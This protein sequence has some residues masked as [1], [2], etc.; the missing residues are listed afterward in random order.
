M[1]LEGGAGA[2]QDPFAPGGIDIASILASLGGGNPAGGTTQAPLANNAPERP[3]G[4][5]LGGTAARAAHAK[6]Q[7]NTASAP[8]PGAGALTDLGTIGGQQVGQVDVR[9]NIM[10]ALEAGSLPGLLSILGNPFGFSEA[11]TGR[12]GGVP[13]GQTQN[14]AAEMMAAQPGGAGAGLLDQFTQGASQGVNRPPNPIA[15]ALASSGGDPLLSHIFGQQP[16]PM[17][18]PTQ[19]LAAGGILDPNQTSIVGENGPELI[20]PG[21]NQVIPLRGAGQAVAGD[22]SGGGPPGFTSL[23]NMANSGGPQIQPPPTGG[24]TPGQA[25][26]QTLDDPIFNFD[27]DKGVPGDQTSVQPIPQGQPQ[28]VPDQM[29]DGNGVL[30]GQVGAGG[31]KG[32]SPQGGVP[33]SPQGPTVASNPAAQDH[34]VGVPQFP[35]GGPAG[36]QLK[37]FLDQLAGGGFG[38]SNSASGPSA[39]ANLDSV[40]RPITERNIEFGLGALANRAPSTFNTAFQ[41]QGIDLAR[42]ATDDHNRTVAEGL[43]KGDANRVADAA[44]QR[45]LTGSLAGTGVQG[46]LGQ[47]Q[48]ETQRELG[49]TNLAN[50]RNLGLLGLQNDRDLGFG[51]QDINR[52]LGFGGLANTAAANQNNFNLGLGAQAAQSDQFNATGAANAQAQAFQQLV[53]PAMQLLMGAFGQATP[54]GLQTIVPGQDPGGK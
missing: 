7:Q 39:N 52:E 12:V 24:G 43:L 26:P 36:G 4:S 23:T 21:N 17:P 13:D 5:G 20:P 28:A 29:S 16:T 42:Q 27:F 48:N 2:G 38:N 41:S 9:T 11:A 49:F 19:G 15:A 18:P 8:G 53:G 40:L 3:G 44:S 45:S 25:G 51:Q 32:G 50:S 37:S 1:G 47:L 35:Q 34:G 54:T 14:R 30:G 6:A 31:A 10:K 22:V 33:N 46:A